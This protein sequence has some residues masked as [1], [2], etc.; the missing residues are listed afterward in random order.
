MRAVGCTPTVV[1]LGSKRKLLV[2]VDRHVSEVH[3]GDVDK[4]GGCEP[5]L[6]LRATAWGRLAAFTSEG[7]V[8]ITLRQPLTCDKTAASQ[9]TWQPLWAPS[10]LQQDF[11]QRHQVQP[12][13]SERLCCFLH[14]TQQQG[15]GQVWALS[16]ALARLSAQGS[17]RPLL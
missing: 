12:M 10:P 5:G 14:I 4:P 13:S 1:T 11:T 6:R 16:A 3:P 8:P 7:H 17:P 15:Q 2:P 9:L